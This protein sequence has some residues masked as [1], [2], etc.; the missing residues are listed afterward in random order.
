METL[1]QQTTMRSSS[2]RR[3]IMLTTISSRKTIKDSLNYRPKDNPME[4]T[5]GSVQDQ[6][7]QLTIQFL[8]EEDP[9]VHIKYLTTGELQDHQSHH[10]PSLLN[11]RDHYQEAL[12]HQVDNLLHAGDL[13]QPP[14]LS[15]E[16]SWTTLSKG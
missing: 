5:D 13:L 7:H 6:V 10:K 15:K 4:I 12:H 2:R 1:A 11:S 14:N 16:A 3:L 9:R 8:R